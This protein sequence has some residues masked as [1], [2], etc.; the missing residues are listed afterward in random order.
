VEGTLV[1]EKLSDGLQGKQAYARL[2]DLLE[3]DLVALLR[4]QLVLGLG[5][6]REVPVPCDQELLSLLELADD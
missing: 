1:E 2:R 4:V 3:L 5:V 6:L